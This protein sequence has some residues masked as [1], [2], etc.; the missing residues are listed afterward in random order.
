M[1][2]TS[3]KTECNDLKINFNLYSVAYSTKA[4]LLSMINKNR[5]KNKL[6]ILNHLALLSLPLLPVSS[7]ASRVFSLMEKPHEYTHIHQR[8]SKRTDFCCW[9]AEWNR[10]VP[11]LFTDKSKLKSPYI[12]A[13][14]HW[15]LDSIKTFQI[16][17]KA[18][19]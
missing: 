19:W 3:I 4:S 12:L 7:K 6:L 1:C 5:N 10:G 2:K 11:P 8:N 18:S 13:A 15:R 16:S 9:Y 17:L 14:C